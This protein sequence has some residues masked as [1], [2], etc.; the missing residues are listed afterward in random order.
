MQLLQREKKRA[1]AGKN[2][3]CSRESEGTTPVAYPLDTYQPH[4]P[5]VEAHPRPA[6]A[7]RRHVHPSAG[8]EIPLRC[9]L[10]SEGSRPGLPVMTR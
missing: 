10:Y 3:S 7:R 2:P 6:P 9:T 4:W 8:R 5:L 1:G